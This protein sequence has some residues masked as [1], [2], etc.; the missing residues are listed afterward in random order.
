MIHRYESLPDLAGI[1]DYSPVGPGD[2][3]EIPTN[4]IMLKSMMKNALGREKIAMDTRAQRI[5]CKVKEV[6]G[7]MYLQFRFEVGG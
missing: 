5:G 7:K 3:V 4:S 6:P 2:I 1:K